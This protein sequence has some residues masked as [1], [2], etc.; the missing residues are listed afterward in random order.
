MLLRLE[1]G[2]MISHLRLDVDPPLKLVVKLRLSVPI[3][4]IFTHAVTPFAKYTFL[5]LVVFAETMDISP[6]KIPIRLKL[7]KIFFM[8][9]S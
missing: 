4:S 3:F 2:N 5:Q 7:N 6:H 1:S 8:I 9:L